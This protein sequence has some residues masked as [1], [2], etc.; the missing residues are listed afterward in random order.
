MQ[1]LLDSYAKD[2]LYQ[3]RTTFRLSG[4]FSGAQMN[5]KNGQVHTVQMYIQM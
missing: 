2:R 1:C 3:N 4:L 5:R